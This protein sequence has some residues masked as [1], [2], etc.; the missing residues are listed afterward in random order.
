MTASSPS[1]RFVSSVRE[2]AGDYDAFILDLWGVIHDGFA[3]FPQSAETLTQLRAAGKATMLLSNAPRRPAVLVDHLAGMGIAR[4]LY[5]AVMS[6]GEAMR[7]DLIARRDPFFAALGEACYHMGPDR[8]LS[9][10]DDV[11]VRRV[12]L[13][14]ADFIVNTGPTEL[15][16][17]LEEYQARLARG[18]ERGLPMVC[19][20]PDKVVIRQGRPVMCAGAMAE[21]Y[22]RLGGAVVYRGK[23]DAAV[24]RT[25]LDELGMDPSRVCVV[26]DSLETDVLGAANAGLDCLFVTG[27]IHAGALGCAYGVAADPER[28]RALLAGEGLSA[29]AVV[30]GFIW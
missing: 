13:E 29:T 25:C 1:P 17:G 14:D 10:F 2:I 16:H 19:A 21:E 12:G 28:V 3:A 23:P 15:T 5:G 27:G 7:R 18:V 6:S 8:D 4:D 22:R 26:G 9:V 20:N 24:Y 30:P 11:A